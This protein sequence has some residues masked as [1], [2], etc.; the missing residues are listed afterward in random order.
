MTEKHTLRGIGNARHSRAFPI[1][2]G[3]VI[4]AGGLIF[5]G[6]AAADASAHHGSGSIKQQAAR[7]ARADAGT[8]KNGN[9]VENV[10][11][12]EDRIEH[13]Y[14]SASKTYPGVGTVTIP[15]KNGNYAKQMR[16]ITAREE[17]YFAKAK[18]HYHG[19][20]KPSLVFDIDDTLVNTY[21]YTLSAQFGYDPTANAV[22][23]DN[24]AFPAV[25][26]MPKLIHE[27]RHEGYK[28]FYITG[29]P[30]SQRAATKKDLKADGYGTPRN[31]HLFL[32]P[33]NPPAYLHCPSTGCST[34]QYKSG[35]RKH[36]SSKG[37]AILGAFGDQYSDLLGGDAGHKVKIPNPMYYI[38]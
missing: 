18:K 34:T 6:L 3:A 31:S 36:I 21:D 27:A 28:I 23:I 13:Y 7:V 16:R 9:K 32:K 4:A 8:P 35:T 26:G 15:A 12:L 24:A 5:G 1:A 11:V 19:K 37:N 17:A 29:R 22:Y 33:T 14:G 38:P 10:N 2:V 30:E 25:F 20:G